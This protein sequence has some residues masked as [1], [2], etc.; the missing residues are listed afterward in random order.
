MLLFI[1]T[2]RQTSAAKHLHLPNTTTI[3]RL[4]SSPAYVNIL[5]SRP[6]PGVGLIT[7][8]R[9]KALNALSTPLMLELNRALGDF[10][11]DPEIGAIV[12][13]GSEKAFAG[14]RPPLFS[15][16][17]GADWR[18]CHSWRRHQRDERQ[19]FRRCLRE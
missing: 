10:D 5:T 2:L 9:P 14:K 11:K 19:N 13:T 1:R 6:D 3:I 17:E 8:N 15:K 7:L 4:M 16:F 18:W 12:L